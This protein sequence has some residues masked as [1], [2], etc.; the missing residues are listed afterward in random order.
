[1]ESGDTLSVIAMLCAVALAGCSSHTASAG[2]PDSGIRGTVL[3]G[4][5]CPV[6]R[7]GQK[8]VRPYQATMTIRALPSHR[9]VAHATSSAG[10]GR[11]SVRLKPG[12]Y[13]LV[14]GAKGFPTR[15]RSQDV[16]VRRHRFT[17]VTITYDSGIR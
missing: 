9:I 5:T 12:R 1:M 15:S 2:R 3:Y 6:Q 4:P 10:T 13:V 16:T 14:P 8:C 17:N 7:Q 11:F